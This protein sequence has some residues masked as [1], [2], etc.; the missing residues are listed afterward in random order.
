MEQQDLKNTISEVS[1]RV[2]RIGSEARELTHT[3]ESSVREAE[4]YMREQMSSHPYRALAAAAAV[5]YVLGGGLA[6]RLTALLLAFGSRMALE[7]AAREMTMR[8]NPDA[9][10]SKTDD[11]GSEQQPH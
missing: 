10:P 8:L 1:D 5:G 11:Y 6:T 7:V 9:R 3:L 4:D 2:G